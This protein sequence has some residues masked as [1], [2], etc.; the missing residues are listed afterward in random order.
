MK[1]GIQVSSFRPV[2]TTREEVRKAFEKMAAMGCDTVQLQWIDPSVSVEF[3]RDTMA[4]RGSGPSPCRI[5]TRRF[6]KTGNT[7][8]R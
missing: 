4:G 3:I 5:F 2:L 8:R 7:T 1:T 6:W